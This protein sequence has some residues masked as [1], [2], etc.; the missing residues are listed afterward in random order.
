MRRHVEFV[1][2]AIMK[3]MDEVTTG[4]CEVSCA[5]WPRR[6]QS[7]KRF[8]LCCTTAPRTRSSCCPSGDTR[9]GQAIEKSRSQNYSQRHTLRSDSTR[10]T[11]RDWQ[12]QERHADVTRAEAERRSSVELRATATN[13]CASISTGHG[14]SLNLAK[15]RHPN[16]TNT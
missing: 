16:N 6:R 2:M 4:D 15:S 8:P 14:S 3:E 12:D 1:A 7:C 11:P 5:L 13:H 10:P 9:Y